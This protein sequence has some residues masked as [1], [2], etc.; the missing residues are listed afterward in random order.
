MIQSHA[1]R[2]YGSVDELKRQLVRQLK[3]HRRKK[4]QVE[5]AIFDQAVARCE[6][7]DVPTV[8][9]RVYESSP[10]MLN[11]V[12][13]M[14]AHAVIGQECVKYF[15]RAR[16]F[17]LRKGRKLKGS[18]REIARKQAHRLLQVTFR[19]IHELG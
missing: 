14:A 15:G 18:R 7:D 6:E 4:L 16:L 17:L 10:A 1:V 13:F 11:K 5:Y 9:C 2:I 12:T 3:F 8:S 19:L